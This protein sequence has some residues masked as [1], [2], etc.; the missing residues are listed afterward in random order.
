MGVM[1]K[2]LVLQEK[3][4]QIGARSSAAHEKTTTQKTIHPKFKG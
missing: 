3:L 2:R 1:K 4:Q